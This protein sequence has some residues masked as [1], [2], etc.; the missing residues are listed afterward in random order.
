MTEIELLRQE[1]A[2]LKALFYKD[3]FESYQAFRNKI[4]LIDADIELSTGT[5]TKIG[6]SATQKLGFFG[7][8][9]VVQQAT[10]NDPTGGTT[11]DAEARTAI[12]LILDRLDTYG[13]TA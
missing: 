4:A 11:V 6:T 2:Q 13:L 7:A 12:G 1:V 3:R 10:I 9:P 8:T 5:G